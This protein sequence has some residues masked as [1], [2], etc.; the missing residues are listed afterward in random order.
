M[1][2]FCKYAQSDNPRTCELIWGYC[3]FQ[4]KEYANDQCP[5]CACL[6]PEKTEEQENSQKIT[7]LL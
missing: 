3:Q 2:A 4:V 1:E 6:R 5:I 7:Y